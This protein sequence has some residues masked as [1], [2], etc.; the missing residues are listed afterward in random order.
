MKYVVMECHYSYAVLLDEEGRFLKAANVNYTEGQIVTDPV[1]IKPRPMLLLRRA[2]TRGAILIV[3]LILIIS[4]IGLHKASTECY[5]AV[6]VSVN[7]E[8][9]IELNKWGKVISVKGLNTEGVRVVEGYDGKGNSA[10]ETVEDIIRAAAQKG[11][12]TDGDTVYF[13]FEADDPRISDKNREI[14]SGNLAQSLRDLDSDIEYC[15]ENHIDPE[16]N[17]NDGNDNDGDGNDND[18]NDGNNEN[19]IG[20]DEA[21]RIALEHAQLKHDEVTDIQVKLDNEDGKAVYEVEFTQNGTE[22]EYEIDAES[23]TVIKWDKE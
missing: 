15:F 9:R 17:Q 13:G 22:Y 1:L 12:I 5:S 8:V 18:G 20:N 16:E 21:T 7:P 11:Y 14:I 4:G 6:L 23:G 10:L 19:Y 3:L 2:L